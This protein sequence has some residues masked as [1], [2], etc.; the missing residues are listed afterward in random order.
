MV[1]KML[2]RDDADGPWIYCYTNTNKFEGFTSRIEW[3]I[4]VH[5]NIL[6]SSIL[7]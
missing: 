3:M 2:H 5:F 1:A 7:R 6:N 4:A